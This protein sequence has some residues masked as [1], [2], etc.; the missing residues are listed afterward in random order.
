[1]FLRSDAAL[2]SE[3]TKRDLDPFFIF[4]DPLQFTRESIEKATGK[5]R[6]ALNTMRALKLA[7]KG[8]EERKY[9]TLMNKITLALHDSFFN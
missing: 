7:P 6:H 8:G 3:S 2:V 4:F 9:E 1:L 5:K